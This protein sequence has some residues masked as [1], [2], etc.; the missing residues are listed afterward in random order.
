MKLLLNIFGVGLLMLVVACGGGGGGSSSESR[1]NPN[2]VFSIDTQNV[3]FNGV[4]GS[5]ET[6]DDVWVVGNVTGA[7]E[8]IFIF[9][10]LTDKGVID[11]NTTV[12]SGN[13]LNIQ[14]AQQD[15]LAPGLHT[16]TVVVKVCNDA[17]CKTQISGSPKSIQVN[18]NVSLPVLTLSQESLQIDTIS[19]SENSS[20]T[21]NLSLNTGSN[22]HPLTNSINFP[23]N[24][25]S[26]MEA[27]SNVSQAQAEATLQVNTVESLSS[28]QSDGEVV[29]TANVS[30]HEV[31]AS[32][33]VEVLAPNHYLKIPDSG[34]ALTSLPST[35]K[36][37]H[38]VDILESTG[39][40]SVSWQASSE[41]SWLSVTPSGLTGSVLSIT[42]DPAGLV[43]NQ[44][45]T[46]T[47]LVSSDDA[48]IEKIQQINV[49]LWVGLTQPSAYSS[50]ARYYYGITA[51][52][53]RPYVYL[54]NIDNETI[55]VY[56]VYTQEIITTITDL[57]T[58]LGETKVS[59][60]GDYLYVVDTAENKMNVI[61]LTDFSI[62][63]KWQSES[64]LSSEGLLVLHPDDRDI[65]IMGNGE[66][67]FADNG[68][69]IINDFSNWSNT[70]TTLDVNLLEN[71]I[72]RISKLL[73]PFSLACYELS[74]SSFK[75]QMSFTGLGE[76]TNIN[77]SGK[78]V[79]IA[80]SDDGDYA[81]VT[82]YAGS[83]NPY[84]IS[85]IDLT[86]LTVVNQLTPTHVVAAVESGDNGNLHFG[87]RTS[88]ATNQM[89]VYSS[90]DAALNAANLSSGFVHEK[91]LAVS[92]DGFVSVAATTNSQLLFM[93]SY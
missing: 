17:Q 80:I 72:C 12:L 16:D 23:N 36:L 18:Y 13:R 55:D 11:T 79:D 56:N 38:Q 37:T 66:V 73:N 15:T 3:E 33:N 42:A 26:V 81:Y 92:A 34:V 25:L 63:S 44:L 76:I 19:D 1:V 41:A 83:S 32:L 86:A 69:V 4:I 51:D 53:V 5:S 85:K 65:L 54:R 48:R 70:S 47:I 87:T 82:A 71:R 46:A 93:R 77:K 28:G 91:G 49:G 90:N 67:L 10:E 7:E 8:N 74:F 2:A 45:Y 35:S 9:I 6:P 40:E 62:E 21:I 59:P 20:A 75:Q 31:S 78:G 30:G 50:V 22:S 43:G 89:M 60:N 24:N 88:F 58:S 39:L 27:S 29:F 52:T 61:D 68:E 14:P 64:S 84:G 57:G